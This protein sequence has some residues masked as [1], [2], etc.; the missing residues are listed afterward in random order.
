MKVLYKYCLIIASVFFLFSCEK[1]TEDISRITAYAT[2]EMQGNNF[3]FVLN[4]STFTDPGVTAYEGEREL[5]IEKTGTVNTSVPGVYVIQYS[6]KNSDGFPASVKRTVAVVSSMP[7]VDLSGA[8]Q[9]VHATRTGKSTITKNGGVLGYYHATDSWYQAYPIPIDFVD[10][11]DGT[12]TIL[13]GSSPYGGH[14]GTGNILPDGQIQFSITLVDQ[15]P[16]VYSTIY[17]LQ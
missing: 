17:Q 13:S 10:M 3:M 11:G 6:A 7:S 1:E 12:I 9:L 2:F 14:Y 5:P 15:G 4:N 8:Y 16:L